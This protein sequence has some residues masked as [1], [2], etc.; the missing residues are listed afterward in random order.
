MDLNFEVFLGIVVIIALIIIVITI[1]NNKFQF[2]IIKIEE[3]EN[4]NA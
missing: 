1:I 4:N 3:A 2:A